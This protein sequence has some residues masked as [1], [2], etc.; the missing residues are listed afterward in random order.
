MSYNF[1]GAGAICEPWFTGLCE[2]FE[3]W[4]IHITCEPNYCEPKKI[5]SQPKKFT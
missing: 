1:E 5:D 4:K 3:L 2:I